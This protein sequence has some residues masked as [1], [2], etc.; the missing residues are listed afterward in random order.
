MKEEE[1]KSSK[2]VKEIEESVK[3]EIDNMEGKGKSTT[4]LVRPRFS[5]I[6]PGQLFDR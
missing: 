6:W 2:K 1:R 4:Q 5:P 3:A